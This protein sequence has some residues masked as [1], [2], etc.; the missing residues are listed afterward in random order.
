MDQ[1]LALGRAIA[2]Q[3]R[4]HGLSQ[5][6][7][8]RL[9]DRPAAWVSE[10]E[11]GLIQMD[12]TSVLE[13]VAGAL[14]TPLPARCADSV[15]AD[16]VSAER[17]RAL[18]QVLDDS[19]QHRAAG[20]NGCPPPPA[21]VLRAKA[22]LAWTLTCDRRY[23]ELAELLGEL[24]PELQAAVRDAS[25]QQRAGLQELTASCYQACAAA[26]ARLGEH[27][28]AKTAAS[29]ALAAAQRA[30][31][32]PLAAASA[33]LLVCILMEL[34]RYPHAD[35]TAR[36]A[37]DALAQ[38]AAEGRPE[39]MSLR[40]ALTLQRALIAARAGDP[41]A[42]ERQLDIAREMAKQ[43]SDGD[44]FGPDHVAL[45]EIAVSVETGGAPVLHVAGPPL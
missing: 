3:R 16:S 32:L 11:R 41:A 33:Y 24:M 23:D 28:N 1:Q 20:P 10:V 26:L 2:E 12:P 44:G 4:R 38:Q 36:K 17:A 13:A 22:D 19:Y 43:V 31:D 37:A 15:A 39:A 8:A 6:E 45:Y 9:L 40:G 25:D 34:R 29:R 27:E 21:A 42:A 30:G 14:G 5:Q 35:E 18:R 7:L